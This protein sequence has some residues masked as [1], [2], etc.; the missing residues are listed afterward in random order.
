M[1]RSLSAVFLLVL[2]VLILP[3]SAQKS[4]AADKQAASWFNNGRDS[5]LKRMKADMSAGDID[6]WEAACK[7]AGIEVSRQELSSRCRSSIL[8]SIPL[9]NSFLAP[10]RN[11]RSAWSNSQRNQSMTGRL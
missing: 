4:V 10:L 5:F 7:K 9:T 11:T 3:A 2:S 1:T 6:A 8:F